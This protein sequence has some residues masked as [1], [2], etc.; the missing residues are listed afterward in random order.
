MVDIQISDEDAN[1]NQKINIHT[2][3]YC[4]DSNVKI[5]IKIGQ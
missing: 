4:T 5:D 1:F 2:K 3:Y